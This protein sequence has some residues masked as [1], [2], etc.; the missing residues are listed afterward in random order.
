MCKAAGEAAMANGQQNEDGIV[1]PSPLYISALKY[2]KNEFHAGLSSAL[3]DPKVAAQVK[4]CGL[5]SRC[6]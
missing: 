2:Y 3:R 1:S 5:V 4:R 6:A